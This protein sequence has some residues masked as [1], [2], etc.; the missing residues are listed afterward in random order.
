MRPRA[1]QFI[2]ISVVFVV[3][4]TGPTGADEIKAH[5]FFKGIDWVKLANKEISAP[6]KP[7]IH[8]ELDT[9]NFSDDFTKMPVVDQPCKPPPNHE[10]LFRGNSIKSIANPNRKLNRN[11][12]YVIFAPKRFFIRR[13]LSAGLRQCTDGSK[14]KSTGSYWIQFKGNATI[15]KSLSKQPFCHIMCASHLPVYSE[16]NGS[17]FKKYTFGCENPIGDGSFSFC[18]KC[19]DNNTQKEYAVKILRSN[20]NVDAEVEALGLCKGHP[21]IVSIEEVIRDDQFIYIVTEWLAGKELFTYAQE[22]PLTESEARGIFKEIIHAVSHMH[23]NKIAHRDLK[24]ENIKF[25]SD[26]TSKANVKILD[27]GFACKMSHDANE[28]ADACY[29]LDYAAPEILSHKKYTESCDLWS[30]GVILYAL[31]TGEMPFRRPNAND[32][33]DK[34]VNST[35]KITYRIKRGQINTQSYRWNTLSEP[36]KDLIRRLLTTQPEKRIKPSVSSILLPLF[37]FYSTLF[38]RILITAIIV[39]C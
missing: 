1:H 10:R 30:L 3:T 19:V 37:S 6:F 34:T 27:F 35:E 11:N 23:S 2:G 38:S 14:A 39:K 16:Q 13:T 4:G 22:Q 21:N 26:N 28:M 7:N 32:C 8:H 18:M 12:L 9:N 29:T 25:T 15:S 17:F 31:L 33:D 5:R 20:Q 24:L 36:A